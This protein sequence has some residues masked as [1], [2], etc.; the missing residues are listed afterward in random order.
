MHTTLDVYKFQTEGQESGGGEEEKLFNGAKFEQGWLEGAL[1]S[2]S[3]SL[4]LQSSACPPPP[5]RPVSWRG[6]GEGRNTVFVF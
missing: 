2:R 1:F 6:G 3:R 5:I 4:R